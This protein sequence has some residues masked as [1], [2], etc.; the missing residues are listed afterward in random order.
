MAIRDNIVTAEVKKNGFGGVDAAR[1]A[2]SLDQIGVTY[3]FTNRPKPS[4]VFDSSYLPPAKES[5]AL[6]PAAP[7]RA[8][9][10]PSGSD[11]RGDRLANTGA[12]IAGQAQNSARL[13]SMQR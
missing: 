5:P 7:A 8:G 2:T 12:T 10:H 6:A 3:N 11:R 4:A 1:L 13:R 9:Q